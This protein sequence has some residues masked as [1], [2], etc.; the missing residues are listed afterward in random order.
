MHQLPAGYH[1]RIA[2][3]ELLALDSAI[4]V[5]TTAFQRRA[6]E[7][8]VFDETTISMPL[9]DRVAPFLRLNHFY[10]FDACLP[11]PTYRLM[12]VRTLAYP[13]NDV[14]TDVCN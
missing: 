11:N 8:M 9:S 4:S 13:L 3:Q 7:V 14:R 6:C 5:R 2:P 12:D 10:Q 1:Y